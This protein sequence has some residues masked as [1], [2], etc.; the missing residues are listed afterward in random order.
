MYWA[1]NPG[2]N[3]SDHTKTLCVSAAELTLYLASVPSQA[4]D[5]GAF[6][7]CQTS[8]TSHPAYS[9]LV[10]WVSVGTGEAGV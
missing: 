4:L 6:S 1:A 10:S 7:K 5:P 8:T 2:T 3:A 9:V